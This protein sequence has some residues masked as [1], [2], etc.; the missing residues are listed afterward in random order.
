VWALESVW[1]TWKSENSWLCRESNSCP[2]VVQPVASCYE[3]F[4]EAFSSVHVTQ[5]RM[6]ELFGKDVEGN[7]GFLNMILSQYCARGS[8]ENWESSR[9]R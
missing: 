1:T 5:R 8:E 3:L 2:S 4:N 9:S 7:G 6:L